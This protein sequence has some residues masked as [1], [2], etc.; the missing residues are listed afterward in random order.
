MPAR[1][2]IAVDLPDRAKRALA[3]AREALL[4]ADPGWTDQKWVDRGLLH[5]TVAFLGSVPDPI[6]DATIRELAAVASGFSE[7]ELRLTGARAVPGLRRA[8]MVWAEAEAD[9][10]LGALRDELLRAAGCDPDPRPFRPH[11]TLVRARRAHRIDGDAIAAAGSI[12]SASG[13][14]PDGSMS[15]PSL[16]LYASTLGACGPS[17]EVLAD[18][19]LAGS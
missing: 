8:T 4:D 13:K 5:V 15:V 7:F 18:L 10:E 3:A 19:E 16:T 2:F 14:G 1:C 12:L 11:V 17:Y 6:L 9:G